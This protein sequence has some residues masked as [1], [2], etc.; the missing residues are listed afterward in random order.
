MPFKSREAR[1]EYAKEYYNTNKTFHLKKA[2]EN[3]QT[4]KGKQSHRISQ[5]KYAGMVSDDWEA[6][7]K[8]YN[9]T[10]NCEFCSVELIKGKGGGNQKHLDH[11][12]ETGEVR[13]ILCG[14]CNVAFTDKRR[15]KEEAE[16]HKKEKVKCDCGSLITRQHLPRHIKESKIH[17]KKMKALEEI[18]NNMPSI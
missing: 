4:E 3:H 17:Q 9:E 2:K 5:W 8:W 7:Y 12:H 10:N 13:H 18:K 16:L 14:K 6:V 1:L 11:N 15:T